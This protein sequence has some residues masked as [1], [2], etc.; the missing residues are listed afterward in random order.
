PAT[1]REDQAVGA[2][3]ARENGNPLPR[4]SL[5]KWRTITLPAD[6][7]DM[8][9]NFC[10]G[11]PTN[12]LA[13]ARWIRFSIWKVSQSLFCSQTFYQGWCYQH[14]CRPASDLGKTSCP[15]A[16]SKEF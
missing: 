16:P 15:V 9:Q 5:W 12:P 11:V 3:I 10:D 2:L 4:E 7:F 14:T 8:A 1:L 13:S 6:G